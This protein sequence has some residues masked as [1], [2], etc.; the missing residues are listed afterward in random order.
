[1]IHNPTNHPVVQ[2]K[3][4]SIKEIYSGVP[5]YEVNRPK[6]IFFGRESQFF[7]TIMT[8]HQKGN[9]LCADPVVIGMSGWPLGPKN[10][11]FGSKNIHFRQSVP[12]N[13]LPN[14]HLPEKQRYP[15]LA[16]DMG[17]IPMS[18]IH[19]RPKK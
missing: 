19:L 7:V 12:K 13:G 15:N 18:Q 3:K 10:S 2:D 14:S 16:Q 11:I 17:K 9:I 5:Q 4:F 8:V 1:M 6:T